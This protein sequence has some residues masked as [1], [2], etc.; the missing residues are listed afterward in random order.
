MLLTRASSAGRKLSCLG[1]R[2]CTTTNAMSSSLM[3][4][5]SALRRSPAVRVGALGA[6][7]QLLV[8]WHRLTT[9]DPLRK[10]RGARLVSSRNPIS[11]SDG[12]HDH[13]LLARHPLAFARHFSPAPS[14]L[15]R[16]HE[17]NVDANRGYYR[18]DNG[19]TNEPRRDGA[20]PA[21]R[22]RLRAA[23]VPCR[24]SLRGRILDRLLRRRP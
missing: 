5:S 15:R 1:A 10:R 18:L 6:H 3:C 20:D 23:V 16:R 2:C 14:F 4:L 12:L 17:I 13:P 24:A 22:R 9:L 8:A 11:S 7:S 21:R 19:A